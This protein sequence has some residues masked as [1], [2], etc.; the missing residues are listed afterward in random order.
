[1]GTVLI[2]MLM[3]A[4]TVAAPPPARAQSNPLAPGWSLQNAASSLRFQSVKKKTVV[5]SSSFATFSGRIDPDG[6]VEVKVL[7][8]SIDTKI[9]LRNVRMR[10]LF[11]ETFQFPEAVITAEIDRAV[12]ADLAQKR[13]IT[14][15][16]RFTFDL[17]GVTKD[18]EMEIAVTLISDDLISVASVAPISIAAG[19]HNLSEGITKLEEAAK[20]DLI[21]SGSVTFDFLFA[22]D[23]GTATTEV[24]A[25]E[26]EKKS[27]ALEATGDFDPAACV[28]RFEILSRAGNIF[29]AP[30]SARLD[31]ASNAL[32]DNLADIV[33]RCP[34]MV[35]EIGGHTDSDGSDATNTALS[36]RRAKA[37]DD[38]LRAKGIPGDRMVTKGYGESQ[39]FVAND[40]A[41]NKARNRRIEFKVVS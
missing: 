40:S 10:F 30:G 18:Y 31:S 25:A 24:A 13:R 28:G 39:P 29:F 41:A 34:G 2:A 16:Q 33:S 5:E 11:F 35:I 17:H 7:L 8:D 1:M 4:L 26:P 3:F 21:P 12:L 23:A 38:Y 37:V 20:V 6:K 27:A 32:L 9:D 19:D 14:L 15:M 22:R 36:E